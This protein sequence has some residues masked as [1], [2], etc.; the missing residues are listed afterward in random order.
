[1]RRG[2][3]CAAGLR[4]PVIIDLQA[5]TIDIGALSVLAEGAVQGWHDDQG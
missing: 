5:E 2:L 3:P 4:I 1:M